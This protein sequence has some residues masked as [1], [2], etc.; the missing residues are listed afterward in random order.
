MQFGH[1]DLENK[2]YF[3][4]LE[5]V[6]ID[7]TNAVLRHSA[8]ESI[9]YKEVN[10]EPVYLGYYFPKNYDKT[11]KY[12]IFVFIHG[13]GWASHRIFDDQTQWSGDYLGYLARYYADRGFLCVSIDYRLAIENGQLPG[14]EIIDSYEDCCDAMD[15]IISHAEEYGADTENMYLLGESAGGHLAGAVATFHYDRRYVFQNVFFIN[16]ITELFDK[17]WF[18]RVPKESRHKEMATLNMKEKARFLSPLYQVDDA[19]GS[20]VLI[21]GEADS[22][23]L[24]EHSKKFYQRMCE[25]SKPCDLHIIEKTNHAFLLA[26]YTDNLTA[27][28]IGI[29]ILNQYLDRKQVIG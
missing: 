3:H 9:I 11:E 7:F 27:C 10:G 4:K 18:T 29:D 15:Y 13:G 24:P 6:D 1:F 23:V 12:P 26:E 16:A 20:V 14:Y 2:E 8:D 22:C 25:L 17:T 5:E 28:K 19:I 21:H